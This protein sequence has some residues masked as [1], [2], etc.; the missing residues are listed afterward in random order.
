M[1]NDDPIAACA[2]LVARGDPDR[3]LAAMAA[4]PAARAPLLTLAAFNLE[5]ARAP[6][7]TKEPLLARM[8][9]QFWRDVI[10]AA[11]TGARPPVHAVAEPLAALIAGRMLPGFLFLQMIDARERDLEPAPF[12]DATALWDYL[13]G[14]SGAL[15]ALS[16]RALGGRADQVA[17]DWGAAQG[18]ANYLMAI[19]A[20]EATGRRPLPDRQAA[21]IEELAGGGLIRLEKAR[22]QR[23]QIVRSAR[24][25][26]LA[27]WR[28]RPILAQAAS[29]PER[30]FAGRLGQSEF[31]RRGSLLWRALT[32][33][34]P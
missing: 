33:T 18:M 12:A 17:R 19:P 13:E 11:E 27:T 8:R 6:W 9:L 29:F 28:A 30:V 14:T 2:A 23:G 24:P 5:V 10:A 16:V 15:M 21:A 20:L 3:F 32:G 31:V 4:P 25:A 34:G 7:V 26:L 22:M 1:S